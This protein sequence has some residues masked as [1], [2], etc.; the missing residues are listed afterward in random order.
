[1]LASLFARAANFGIFL[2]AEIFRSTFG[3]EPI[4]KSPA[5][6]VSGERAIRDQN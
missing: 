2:K 5:A 1:M 6:D 4:L 3:G